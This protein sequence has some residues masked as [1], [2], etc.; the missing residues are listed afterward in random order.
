MEIKQKSSF[1]ITIDRVLP[2][3]GKLLPTNE[4]KLFYKLIVSIEFWIKSIAKC[5][6]KKLFLSLALTILVLPLSAQVEVVISN[7][8]NDRGNIRVA[9]FSESDY[10]KKT[11]ETKVVKSKAGELRIVLQN[12]PDGKYAVNVLH[13]ENENGEIDKNFIG[14]PKEG[15]AF[16]NNTGK[17]G[18][19]D[20]K[21]ASF[22]FKGS[23]RIELNL[24]YYWID[25]LHLKSIDWSSP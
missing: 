19:P 17:F 22:E 24:I 4:S 20:F 23:T 11:V 5:M 14:I 12:I 9:L 10:L 25:Q 6:L 2:T 3:L 21:E 18:P 15:Y 7:V 16:S 13:D 1:E 8:K